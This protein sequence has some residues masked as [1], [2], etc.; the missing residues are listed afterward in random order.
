M[1]SGKRFML[2]APKDHDAAPNVVSDRGL[3]YY[4]YFLCGQVAQYLPQMSPRELPLVSLRAYET[5]FR[6]NSDPAGFNLERQGSAR[7][8]A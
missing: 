6:L 4:F 2:S 5:R 1:R 7:A 3:Y 8:H